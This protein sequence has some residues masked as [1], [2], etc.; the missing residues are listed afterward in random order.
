MDEMRVTKGA[1]RY[2]SNFI[3]NT[4]PFPDGLLSK[5]PYFSRVSALMPMNGTNG[6]TTYT[7][8]KGK[9]VTTV[10]TAPTTSTSQVKVGN[11]A[12]S[13]VATGGLEIAPSPDFLFTGDFTIESWVY[14][15]TA[16]PT[17]FLLLSSINLST[18]TDPAGWFL[19]CSGAPGV[20]LYYNGTSNT[21]N[22]NAALSAWNHIVIARYNGVLTLYMNGV[23]TS[24]VFPGPMGIASEK[25]SIGG[26][27]GGS[28]A[29]TTS[30]NFVGF[31]DGLRI[32]KDVARYTGDFIPPTTE[33]PTA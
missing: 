25:L 9:T 13:L 16:D 5:D 18:T 8:V 32:T 21:L 30:N 29:G 20:S 7:E 22:A 11:A 24:A 1:S 3:P 14:Q 12:L 33:Y 4:A 2:S 10:G 19:M 27:T 26:K 23:G 6:G 17:G 28:I 15:S 31:I